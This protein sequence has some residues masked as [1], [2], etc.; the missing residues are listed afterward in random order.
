M[1]TPTE[2]VEALASELAVWEQA[3]FIPRYVQ[4]AH[5]GIY[6][7]ALQAWNS[8]KDKPAT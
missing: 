6:A 1:S 2:G 4:F 5:P 3:M 7:E 8:R